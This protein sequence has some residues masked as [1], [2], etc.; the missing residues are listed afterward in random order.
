M[1]I[2]SG[3]GNGFSA[4]VNAEKRLEVAATTTSRQHVISKT[5]QKSF[6]VFGESTAANGT[7]N[8][9]HLRNQTPDQTFTV[10]YLRMV[11]VDLAGGTAVPSA[12]NYFSVVGGEEYSSGGVATTASSVYVGSS[13]T[14]SS[15]HYDDN[16]TLTGSGDTYD[17]FWPS[18]DA[19]ERA[20][21]KEG[22]LI[23]PPGE[24]LT[25]KFTGDNTSGTLYARVSYY[26]TG[27]NSFD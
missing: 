1:I 23:I 22:S 11:A 6:Q 19:D 26:V 8:V 15:T 10:T 4:N 7:V 25:I 14:D 20:Y 21:R 5:N 18:G 13:V 24:S 3:S 17:K 2:D 12:G 16:P 27:V 9:L